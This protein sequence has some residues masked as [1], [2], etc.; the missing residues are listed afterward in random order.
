MAQIITYHVTGRLN[1]VLS[2]NVIHPR[3]LT[4]EKYDAIDW[5]PQEAFDNTLNSC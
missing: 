3:I 5:S 2:D 4:P 1:Q